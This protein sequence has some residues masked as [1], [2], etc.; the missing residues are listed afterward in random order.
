VTVTNREL[1]F[2][3]E[4]E[5]QEVSQQIQKSIDT[6][7]ILEPFGKNTAPAIAAA[8]L[9]IK[10]SYGDD[11]IILVLA[12][13]HLISN[14]DTFSDAVTRACV[15]AQNGKLVTF[16]INPDAPETGYGYIE[17]R[18]Q[19]VLRFNEKPSLEKAKEYVSTDNFYWNSGIF[20]FAAGSMLHEMSI[21]CPD[22]LAATD[23]C[24]QHSRV[25]TGEG[26]SQLELNPDYFNL[27]PENSVDYAVMEKTSN[28]SVIACDIGWS[29]IGCWRSLGELKKQ[30]SNN[31]NIHGDAVV[32]DSNNCTVSSEDRLVGLV[33][34]EGLVIVDTADALLVADKTRAQDVKEIYSQLKQQGHEAHKLH[35]TVYRPWGTYTVLGEGPNFKIKRINVKRGA[36]LSLQKHQYRSE[37]WVVIAGVAKVINE[38]QEFILDIDESTF[39]PAGHMHRLENIGSEPLIMIEVQ[40]GD[41][42]G[43]DDIIRYGDIYGRGECSDSDV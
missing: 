22:I 4:D 26:F 5:Y 1:F 21:H 28:A 15:L 36:S 7:F 34:V 29:D 32:I 31:N 18:G 19:D 30:D 14:F 40:T 3:I 43:E 6:T 41:Y 8:S 38:Q 23:S 35:R 42:L 13:D 10:E 11:A 39:V 27:V 16:G 2:K 9:K 20:C 37:H 12:A 24:L 17:A 25:A 33:G